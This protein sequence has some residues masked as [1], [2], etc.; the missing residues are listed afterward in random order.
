MRS[1]VKRERGAG[2]TEYIIM[3]CLIAIFTIGIVGLFGDNIRAL[4]ATGS[5]ALAGNEDRVAPTQIAPPQC[6]YT[7]KGVK[8]C[9]DGSG[10]GG[11]GSSSSAVSGSGSGGGSSPGSGASGPA[12]SGTGSSSSA[13][14][15]SGSSS[16]APSSE[17]KVE[18]FGKGTIAEKGKTE[19]AWGNQKDDP[20]SDPSKKKKLEEVGVDYTLVDK[21]DELGKI[22]NDDNN[23]R[24]GALDR[25]LSLGAK[26]DRNTGQAS[27]GLDGT[28]RVTG[29]EANGKK[30]FGDSKKGG[31]ASIGGQGRLLT[32]EATG[33]VKGTW[34][35]KEGAAAEVDAGIGAAVAEGNIDGELAYRIPEWVPWVGGGKVYAGGELSGS[36]LS[37]Q[38]KVNGKAKIGKKGV[39]FSGGAK[40]GALLAGLGFKIR[41]GITFD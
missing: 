31:S 35:P 36:L 7:L 28:I 15:S 18:G 23:V 27:V 39:E 2:K 33:S 37:A 1:F 26:Y 9:S 29:V 12:S 11:S 30:T 16:G 34:D 10:T 25:N 22:G 41:G 24:L 19:K 13:V 4:F 3:V 5:D 14:S 20:A 8:V 40:V 21:K 38:A 32:A 17:S 6:H